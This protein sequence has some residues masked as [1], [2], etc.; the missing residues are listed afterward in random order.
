M[1]LVVIGEKPG[2]PDGN[3]GQQAQQTCTIGS[4]KTKRNQAN[5]GGSV[6]GNSSLGFLANSSAETT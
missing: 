5:L 4:Q 1:F 2:N 3:P 6:L